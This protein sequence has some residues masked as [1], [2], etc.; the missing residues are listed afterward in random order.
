VGSVDLEQRTSQGG[1]ASVEQRKESPP[2]DPNHKM[3]DGSAP[4]ND[5]QQ[6]T[7]ESGNAGSKNRQQRLKGEDQKVYEVGY[8]EGHSSQHL[9]DLGLGVSS[10]ADSRRKPKYDLLELGKKMDEAITRECFKEGKSVCGKGKRKAAVALSMGV[11]IE[12]KVFCTA[13]KQRMKSW[14]GGW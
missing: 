12:N 9:R 4:E 7:S 3:A 10:N 5:L 2:R 11:L 14:P 1:F 8:F 13:W 6:F